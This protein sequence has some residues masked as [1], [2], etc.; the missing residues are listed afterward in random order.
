MFMFIIMRIA[1]VTKGGQP[2]TSSSS[3]KRKGVPVI[4]SS[5]IVSVRNAES[6]G[7]AAPARGVMLEVETSASEPLILHPDINNNNN[8]TCDNNDN[9]SS[10]NSQKPEYFVAIVFALVIL[11]SSL[12]LRGLPS[13]GVPQLRSRLIASAVTEIAAFVRFKGLIFGFE[14][15]NAAVRLHRTYSDIYRQCG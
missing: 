12:Y 6:N 3:I 11:F 8:S 5:G 9:N 1:D 7:V 15:S 2:I 13:A 14:C 10:I 4:D